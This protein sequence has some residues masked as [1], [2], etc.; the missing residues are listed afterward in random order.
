MML[1]VED[2]VNLL[3]KQQEDVAQAEFRKWLQKRKV[4]L[5]SLRRVNSRGA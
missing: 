1:E 5:A 3:Y 2:I 4:M